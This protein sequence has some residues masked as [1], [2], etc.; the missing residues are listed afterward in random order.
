MTEL[1]QCRE[2]V[3]ELCGRRPIGKSLL[4]TLRQFVLVPRVRAKFPGVSDEEVETVCREMLRS[5]RAEQ[6]RRRRGPSVAPTQA[7]G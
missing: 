3:W 7:N 4:P 2:Y 5:E 1:E 6:R